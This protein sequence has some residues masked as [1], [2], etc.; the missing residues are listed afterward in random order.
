[1]RKFIVVIVTLFVIA[2]FFLLKPAFTGNTVQEYNLDSFANCVTQS[3]LVMYGTDWCPHCLEQ[4]KMFDK[5][6][7]YIDYVNCDFKSEVCNREGITGYPTWKINGQ[8]YPG[9]QELEEL[10][11]LSG[12]SLE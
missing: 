1:M 2:L 7:K 6:F 11:A 9:V 4:K 3:G 5:S 8:R 10:A 12:C